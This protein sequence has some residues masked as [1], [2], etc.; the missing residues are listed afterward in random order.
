[1][2]RIFLFTALLGLTQVAFSQS[3]IRNIMHDGIQREYRLYEPAIY[4]GSEAVPLV[5]NLHGYTSNGFEQEVYGDFRPI[6][7]TA[8]FI[9]IHPEGTLDN[10]GI[11]FWNAFGSPTE[12]VDDVGFISALIDSIAAEYNIDMNRVY[13]TGMSNGGFMS[14]YLAC[15]LSYRIT[16]IASVT[17]AMIDPAFLACNAV[18]PTPVMQIHG[19]LDPTVPYLGSTGVLGAEAAISYWVN[20]NNCNATAIETAVPDVNVNDGCTADHFLY[21][22]GDAGS[23]VELYRVNGGGHTWPGANPLFA[24][25]VT[26][27]DFSASVEIWRFFSQYRLNE[28]TTGIDESQG[29]VPFSVYPNPSN[30]IVSV[31]FENAK[32]R[33]IQVRNALGQLVLEQSTTGKNLELEIPVSGIH[34]LSVSSDGEFFTQK[35]INK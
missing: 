26:N 35:L 11:K 33:N 19:T 22:G 3:V 9:L 32:F 17:G 12:T 18:H 20:Y 1:M 16:A 25:G 30:G 5:I 29:P 23:S 28:L 8:N 6:A 10:S 15:Q 34:F 4:D 21:Q 2:K 14:Y 13:S 27:Q 24:I 7:D 31:Q